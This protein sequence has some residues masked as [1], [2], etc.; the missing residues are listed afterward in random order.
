MAATNDVKVTPAYASWKTT[1]GLIEDLHKTAIPPKVDRTVMKK[2]SGSAQSQ[3]RVALRFLG[4]TTDD[5]DITDRMK[6]LVKAFGTEEWKDELRKVVEDAYAPILGAVPVENGTAQQ[7]HDAFRQR[8]DVSGSSFRKA[9]RFFL[10]AA[11]E[12]GMKVSPHFVAPSAPSR[13]RTKGTKGK[14]NKPEDRPPPADKTEGDADR[15]AARNGDSPPGTEDPF[16]S[17]VLQKLPEFDPEWEAEAQ[18]AFFDALRT[19]VQMKEK[20]S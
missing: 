14:P 16:W 13:A 4:L 10:N 18:T 12:S 17:Q 2:M 5:D 8:T 20:E 15:E 1:R 6:R 3:V 19:V 9:V 7:L 11:R